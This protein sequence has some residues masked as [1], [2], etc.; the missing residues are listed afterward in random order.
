MQ[1]I[2]REVIYYVANEKAKLYCG[3][4]NIGKE[5]VEHGPEEADEH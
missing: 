1:E 5:V 3:E 4:Q 2:V